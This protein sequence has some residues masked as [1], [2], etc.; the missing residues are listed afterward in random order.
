MIVHLVIIDKFIPPFI[1]LVNENFPSDRHRFLITGTSL[2]KYSLPAY[3]NVEYINIRKQFN[4]ILKYLYIG[5]KLIIHG[6]WDE[7]MIKVLYFQPW[8]LKKCYH[9]MWGGD[10]YNPESQSPKKKTV[11]RKMGHFISQISGDYELVKNWYGAKGMLHNCFVYPSNMYNQFNV[12]EKESGPLNIMVGNSCDP[13]NHHIEIINK[14][15]SLDDEEFNIICPLS[16]GNYDVYKKEVINKGKAAFGERFKPIVEF[17]DIENYA[18]LIGSID[19]AIFAHNRQQAMGNI[20]ML[21]GMGKKVYLRS[22]TS[23]YLAMKELGISVF[24]FECIDLSP[25]PLSDRMRNESIIV[26]EFSKQ[27]LLSQL[28]L[29]F[30]SK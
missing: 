8:L 11:I 6:L 15:I 26:S 16:Y 4:K 23:H 21:L 22:G 17:L 20:V 12:P 1:K 3:P 7:R 24:D 28:G 30:D 25:L 9:V 13:S 18:K 5:E 29:I 14:L 27:K 19:I 2:P 10:F